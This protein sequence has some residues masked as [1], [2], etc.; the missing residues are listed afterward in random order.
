MPLLLSPCPLEEHDT[1]Q[2]PTWVAAEQMRESK[3][4]SRTSGATR[5]GDDVRGAAGLARYRRIGIPIAA[6]AGTP[7]AQAVA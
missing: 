3:G 6:M 4:L 2:S 7:G 1:Y 5:P